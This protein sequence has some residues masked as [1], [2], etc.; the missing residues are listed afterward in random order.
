MLAL[1]NYGIRGVA[2][3]L[4]NYTWNKLQLEWIYN[5]HNA[6]RWLYTK[7]KALHLPVMQ[8]HL[9]FSNA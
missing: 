7:H 3:T 8:W 4:I 9:E 2:Y 5:L 6:S 1:N